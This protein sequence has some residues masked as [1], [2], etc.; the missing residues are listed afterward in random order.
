MR[1]YFIQYFF[2]IKK[3]AWKKIGAREM[4]QKVRAKEV[5]RVRSSWDKFKAMW[6]N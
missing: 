4:T 5:M 2:L 3:K 1:H 6:T